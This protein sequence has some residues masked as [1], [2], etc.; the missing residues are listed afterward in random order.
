MSDI[1]RERE[2]GRGRGELSRG[3]K[4]EGEREERT[5]GESVA[6]L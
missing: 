6:E 3:I 1:V 4:A 5:N 2:W